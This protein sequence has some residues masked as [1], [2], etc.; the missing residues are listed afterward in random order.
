MSDNGPAQQLVDIEFDAVGI[1]IKNPEFAPVGMASLHREF[2]VTDFGRLVYDSILKGIDEGKKV[3]ASYIINVLTRSKSL[4]AAGGRAK[5]LR[6]SR[7]AGDPESFEEY[8]QTLREAHLLNEIR[9]R[10]E[11]LGSVEDVASAN[12]G[13]EDIRKRLQ[14]AQVTYDG[15]TIAEILPEAYDSIE[16]MQRRDVDDGSFGIPSGYPEL[17]DLIVWFNPG[18][19]GVIGARPSIG[20]TAFM[21]N[22]AR[23]AA[24]LYGKS[25]GIIS[26]EMFRQA[27]VLRML[28][29]QAKVD[30]QHIRKGDLAEQEYDRLANAFQVYKSV[31][32]LI[33]IND[34]VSSFR[35]VSNAIEVMFN[36]HDVDLCF[37]DYLQLISNAPGSSKYEQVS[38]CSHLM[39]TLSKRHPTKTLIALAQLHR[40]DDK[41][42]KIPRPTMQDLKGAGEIEQDADL[43]ILLHRPE[44]YK[45]FVENGVS[46]KGIAELIVDKQR[47]G[48]TGIRRIGFDEIYGLFYSKAGRR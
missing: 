8:V 14:G 26:V 21:L 42:K 19:Y 17:D 36:V 22:R 9:Q 44:K 48:P 6:A 43:I 34:S 31:G 7:E 41:K 28:C 1:L 23:N 24:L 25:S 12:E 39:K 13:I 37:V 4:K 35:D 18:D 16:S 11:Q 33:R 20:K 38:A 29:M 10:A 2:L 15:K 30:F 3:S 40:M 46:T 47:N 45:V 32:S 5:I 27:L